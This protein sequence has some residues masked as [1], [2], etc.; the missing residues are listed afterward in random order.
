LAAWDD[1]ILTANHNNKKFILGNE[2]IECERGELITSDRKLME[3]WGW[4]KSKV[5]AFLITLE[6]DSMVDIKRSQK[7]T[8]IKIHQYSDYQN[9]ETAN[10]PTKDRKETDKRPQRDPNNNKKEIKKDKKEEKHK[11]KN[12]FSPPPVEIVIMYFQEKGVKGRDGELI[13]NEFV[14][15]YQSNGWLVGSN[16]MKDWKASVRTWI[17]RRK[18]NPGNYK[19][20]QPAHIGA[21]ILEDQTGM[22]IDEIEEKAERDKLKQLNDPKGYFMK[23]HKKADAG[24]EWYGLDEPTCNKYKSMLRLWEELK[25][26]YGENHEK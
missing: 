4:S 23:V 20:K 8:T 25:V 6:K 19:T 1:L 17:S 11:G 16:K 10:K 7:K 24:K 15:F 21:P 22:T 18:S 26:K 12:K 14:D 5:R 2:V 13:G 3:R 9:L